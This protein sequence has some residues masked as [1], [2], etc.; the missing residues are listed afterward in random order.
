M[1]NVD[2]PLW[3]IKLLGNMTYKC[4][5]LMLLFS[6]KVS[7]NTHWETEFMLKILNKLAPMKTGRYAHQI[8]IPKTSETNWL[9]LTKTSDIAMTTSWPEPSLHARIGQLI[10][11]HLHS[12]CWLLNLRN[13]LKYHKLN[14]YTRLDVWYFD[15]HFLPQSAVF[16]NLSQD[17]HCTVTI[18]LHENLKRQSALGQECTGYL[19]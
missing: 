15:W 5:F 16:T 17:R 4:Q 18:C 2:R 3:Y 14:V 19:E 9:S 12:S 8:T 6:V 10:L 13:I 7:S 11:K 1:E